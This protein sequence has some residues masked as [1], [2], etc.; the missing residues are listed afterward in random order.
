MLSSLRGFCGFCGLLVDSELCRHVSRRFPEKSAD[1]GQSLRSATKE[2]RAFF[3]L[4]YLRRIILWCHLQSQGEGWLTKVWECL[5]RAWTGTAALSPSPRVV[6][7]RSR[8]LYSMGLS[9]QGP[10]IELRVDS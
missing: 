6:G 2:T 3:A 10:V 1:R 8:A 7:T 9:S 4:S 5:E